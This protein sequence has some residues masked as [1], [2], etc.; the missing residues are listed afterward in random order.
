MYVCMYV[1]MHACIHACA[2]FKGFRPIT[3]HSKIYSRIP[4]Y[5]EHLLSH[6][7]NTNGYPKH[8]KQHTQQS[9]TCGEHLLSRGINT[10]VY[11]YNIITVH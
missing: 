6:G 10:D 3:F 1:C 2:T 11:L 9:N 4:G 5:G 8:T 7:I